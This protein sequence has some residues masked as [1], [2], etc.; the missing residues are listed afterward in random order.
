MPIYVALAIASVC[1]FSFSAII[2][3]LTAKYSMPNP[4]AWFFWYFFI[5]FMLSLTL[6]LFAPIKVIP[7]SITQLRF[8]LPYAIAIYTAIFFFA[9]ALYKLDVSS[10]A[11]LS[12]L[13]NVFVPLLA[14]LFLGEKMSSSNIPWF[15]LVI[16]CGFLATYDE[17]LKLRSFLNKYVYFY[18][19][20]VLFLSITRIFANKGINNLGYWNFTFYE[21]F[22]GSFLLLLIIPFIYKKIQVK[23]K[24]ILFM[25]PGVATEFLG[26]L[27]LLKALSYQVIVPQIITSIPLSSFI[28]FGISRLDKDLL[29]YHPLQTYAIRFAG[30]LIMI[31]GVIK[32]AL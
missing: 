5:Y 14:F 3:K 27:F 15:I 16:I 7:T 6:P 21:F 31:V 22:Y 18:L 1:L 9:Q 24:L 29:E 4:L 20:F 30:I 17:R 2:Y 32:L 26:V 13:G 10:M 12:N 25:I 8:N 23:P 28:A 11:P 19:I